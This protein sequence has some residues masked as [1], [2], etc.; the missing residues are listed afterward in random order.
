LF[1]E[2][3]GLVFELKMRVGFEKMTKN[4]QKVKKRR[5]QLGKVR[6]IEKKVTK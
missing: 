6:K 3:G 5:K 4:A 2:E 1:G